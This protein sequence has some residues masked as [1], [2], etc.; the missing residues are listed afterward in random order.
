MKLN[1]TLVLCLAIVLSVSM[2]LG[3]T[4]AYLQDSVSDVNVMKLGMTLSLPSTWMQRARAW[5]LMCPSM[6]RR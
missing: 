1:R 6:A 3:G 5:S 2:A 4:L